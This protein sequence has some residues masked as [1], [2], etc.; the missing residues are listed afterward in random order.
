ME[1]STLPRAGGIPLPRSPALLRGFSDERLVDQV[2]RGNDAAFEVVYDRHHRGLL[3]FCRHIL[4]SP[5]EAE[6]AVQQTFI[7]AYAD[8]RASDKPIKLKAWLYT[9]ARNRCLSVLRARREQAAELDDVPTV[10]LSEEVQHRSELQQL[11]ADMRELPEQQRAALVLS[12][13]GDLS[14]AEIGHVVGVEPMKVK[15]LVFQARSSLLE[16]RNA[17][18]TSCQEIREQLATLRGGALRRGPLRKHLRQCPGCAEYR[19][20]VKRQRQLIAAVL[21]VLPS[22]GLR[23]SILAAIGGGGAGGAAATAGGGGIAALAG[24]GTLKAT[25]VVVTAVAIGG[26]GVA[27]TH[28]VYSSGGGDGGAETTRDLGRS[29]TAPNSAAAN[30]RARD[31]GEGRA[32]PNAS[33]R[34]RE[35]S[36]RKPSRGRGTAGIRMLPPTAT[37]RGPGGIAATPNGNAYGHNGTAPGQTSARGPG[38]RTRPRPNGGGPGPQASPQAGGPGSRYEG[39]TTSQPGTRSGTRGV[40][41][42]QAQGPGAG[43]APPGAERI[44]VELP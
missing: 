8:L 6:D 31:A 25:A 14:H 19:E 32:N 40:R 15:S 29:S 3:S 33:A 23:E 2:R 37:G 11:L 44:A 42:P 13:L 17:R 12:E 18:E 38:V 9:I 36:G 7:S 10:G 43:T 1:A 41:P 24:G 35:R 26:G 16:S 34:G 21:P 27:V 22:A 4:H 39:G 30:S 28:D 5:D 20:E